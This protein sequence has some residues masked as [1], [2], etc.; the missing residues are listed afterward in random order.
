[1]ILQ[2]SVEGRADTSMAQTRV[3]KV[4]VYGSM[5]DGCRGVG[6]VALPQESSSASGEVLVCAASMAAKVPLTRGRVDPTP[7]LRRI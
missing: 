5:V 2:V 3:A 6:T 4:G 1:M 7:Y